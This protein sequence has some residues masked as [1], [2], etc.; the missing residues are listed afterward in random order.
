V[1]KEIKVIVFDLGRVM[2]DF[3]HYI[4][5][6][7]LA[8]AAGKSPQEIFDLFFDSPLIQS[9]EEGKIQPGEFFRLVGQALGLK[10]SFEEF[11]PV[12]NQIFIFSEEN[13]AV[14]DLG[15]ILKKRYR[16]A[17]LSNINALHLDYLKRN[18]PVFDIFHD[19]FASCEMGCIKPDPEIYRRVISSLGVL[20]EEIFYTDD[21]PE[22][23]EQA[24]KLGMRGF[25]F[26]GSGKLKA[27]LASCGVRSDEN[28]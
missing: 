27:D 3:D 2:V 24:N 11:L 15:R 4:A 13:K 1:D 20:P 23:I 21:R 9:F 7:K 19:I 10:I 5:A 25:V 17:L 12:W 8:S 16:V 14:H 22:L 26:K 28:S 6:R 18:F